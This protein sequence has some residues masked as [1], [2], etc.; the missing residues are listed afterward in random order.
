MP[1]R[2]DFAIRIFAIAIVCTEIARSKLTSRWTLTAVCVWL[3]VVTWVVF[4]QTLSIDFVNYDDPH[5][6][7]K[8]K[9]HQW[10]Q[11]R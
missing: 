1:I 8:R 5:Y 3:T 10:H 7:S 11:L 4:A 9:D 6:V 2:Y